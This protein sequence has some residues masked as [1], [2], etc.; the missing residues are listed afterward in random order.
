MRPALLATCLGVVLAHAPGGAEPRGDTTLRI[1]PSQAEI[2]VF[3]D[4]VHLTV[5]ADVERD[6]AVAV[7]MAGPVSDLHLRTLAQVW[8]TFWAPAGDVSFERIPV[9]YLLHTSSALD[10]L[11]P[12]AVL[13]QMGIGYESFRPAVL[14]E[15]AQALFPDLIGLKESEGLFRSTAGEI[16]RVPMD[17][18]G[19]RI[20]AFLLVPARAPAATYRIQLFGFRHHKVVLRREGAFTLER[21]A[22][23]AFADSLARQ[24][25]L[26]YGIVAVAVAVGGGLLVGLVFG[27]GKGH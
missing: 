5:S 23:N 16:E 15:A 2:G 20:S 10:D 27:S 25:G 7:L 8:G 1:V 3:Y 6:L 21:G 17:D 26:I 24:H 22:F 9:L 11:A 19:Q 12:A 14:E 13:A 4:G 18:G